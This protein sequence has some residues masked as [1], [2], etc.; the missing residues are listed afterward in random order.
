MV[1]A[2]LRDMK[3]LDL[4]SGYAKEQIDAIENG[5]FKG[6]ITFSEVKSI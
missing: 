5:T 6:K 2:N 4:I 1:I 3:E